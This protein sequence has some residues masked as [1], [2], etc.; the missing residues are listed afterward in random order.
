M[1]HTW[2]VAAFPL[3]PRAINRRPVGVWRVTDRKEFLHV[4]S[5]FLADPSRSRF[6]GRV[7]KKKEGKGKQRERKR[8]REREETRGK[9]HWGGEMSHDNA[10][11]FMRARASLR[12]VNEFPLFLFLQEGKGDN[13]A[14]SL[15]P[16]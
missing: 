5:T 3:D 8:E 4:S 6:N 7:R 16:R 2:C 11:R 13:D 14:S 1:R 9:F 12:G 15:L 10:S